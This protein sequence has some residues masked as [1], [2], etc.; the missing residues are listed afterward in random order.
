MKS[1]ILQMSRQSDDADDIRSALRKRLMD[2]MKKAGSDTDDSDDDLPTSLSALKK[3]LTKRLKHSGDE[4]DSDSS[5]E[6]SMHKVRT[7]LY[8]MK[9]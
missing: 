3:A 6:P 4:S 8:V 2:R 5:D 9:N 1:A 7:F